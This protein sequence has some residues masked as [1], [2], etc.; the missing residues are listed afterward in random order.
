MVCKICGSEISK[1]DT[2]CRVCGKTVGQE[3]KP[4]ILKIPEEN[5][6][7]TQEKENKQP[8]I[9]KVCVSADACE[10]KI[11]NKDSEIQKQNKTIKI[12][13]EKNAEVNEKTEEELEP[14]EAVK[15]EAEAEIKTQKEEKNDVAKLTTEKKLQNSAKRAAIRKEKL[16]KEKQKKKVKNS[17]ILMKVIVSLCAVLTVCLTFVSG[18]TGIFRDDGVEKT[19]ALSILLP[20]DSALFEETAVKYASLFSSGYN[21]E[22]VSYEDMLKYM[23]PESENGLYALLNKKAEAVENTLDP[24]GRFENTAYTKVSAKSVKNVLSSL[25]LSILNDIN[26]EDYYYYD[27]YY[28]FRCSNDTQKNQSVSLKVSSAKKTSEGNYYIV[29]SVTQ[30]SKEDYQMYFLATLNEEADGKSWSIRKI[31]STALYDDFGNAISQA[32]SEN[33]LSYVMKRKTVTAKTKSGKVYAKYVLEYPYFNSQ[34]GA[35]SAINTLYTQKIESFKELAKEES[36]TILYKE[37]LSS[38]GSKDDLPL[39]T[40]IVASVKLNDNGYF[41]L[42]ERTAQYNPLEKAVNGTENEA[43]STESEAAA[44]YFPTTTYESYTFDIQSGEFV[45]KDD[46]TGKDYLAVQQ[47]LYETYFYAVNGQDAVISD[48][49]DGIG[50]KIY[51]SAWSLT[52]EGMMFSYQEEDGALKEITIPYEKLTERT[53]MK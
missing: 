10:K 11:E 27:G 51:A 34:S 38:G 28:Y 18:F 37:Y 26:D 43:S 14:Q 6:C 1:D 25:S 9:E 31:S 42:V 39:Y 13:S 15:T 47:L 53:V 52:E 48:D 23:K 45:K 33:S 19:V 32:D 17:D 3:K 2:F 5:L 16:L 46:V 12:Q 21:C 30:G 24:A 4:F 22:N 29:C 20:S 41:S 49:T 40:H 36:T 7:T 35:E 44:V 8:T 50:A